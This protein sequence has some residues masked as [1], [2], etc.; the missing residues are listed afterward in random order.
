ML[1]LIIFPRSLNGPQSYDFKIF[2]NH[3]NENSHTWVSE[4]ETTVS[5]GEFAVSFLCCSQNLSPLF[6]FL[7]CT[8]I[9]GLEKSLHFSSVAQP[10]TTLCDP[11]NRRMPGLPVHHQLPEFT[12]TH[13]HR[14]RNH[15]AISSS[16]IPFSCPQSLPASESF[17]LSQLFA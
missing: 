6:S 5:I 9:L 17:L 15:P 10:C 3:Y 1:N 16:V 11:M 4:A 13:A 14:V 7:H 12:Q 8:H 2:K